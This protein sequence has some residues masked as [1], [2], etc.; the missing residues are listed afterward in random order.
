MSLSDIIRRRT[1]ATVATVAVAKSERDQAANTDD[2]SES[3]SIGVKPSL[4]IYLLDKECSSGVVATATP[5]T[6]A[7]HSDAGPHR[8]DI[9]R[10]DIA[11]VQAG[12]VARI[13]SGTCADT[14][15]LCRDDEARAGLLADGVE[16]WRVWTLAEVRQVAGRG[17]EYVRNVHRLRVEMGA[18]LTDSDDRRTCRD[19]AEY[20]EPHCR[21]ALRGELAATGRDYLPDADRLHR[22]AGYRAREVAA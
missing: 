2:C 22:C 16:P 5:A 1:V 7:T 18:T 14:L 6:F 12:A 11:A 19:C 15:H 17:P 9:T 10:D 21:A 4:S 8:R 13:W 3:V 20:A